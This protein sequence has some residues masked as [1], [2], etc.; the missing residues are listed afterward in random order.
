VYTVGE[1]LPRYGG[2]AKPPERLLD[3]LPAPLDNHALSLR[4]EEICSAALS[5]DEDG[6][7]SSTVINTQGTAAIDAEDNDGEQVLVSIDDWLDTDEQPWGE[8]RFVIG[9]I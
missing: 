4:I 2:D 5:E 8:E 3:L 7:S 6:P 1:G 9:P